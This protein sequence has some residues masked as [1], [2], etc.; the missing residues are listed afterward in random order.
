MQRIIDIWL[1]VYFTEPILLIL[2][3]LTL[4]ISIVRRQTLHAF[5]WLPL[6]VGL[7]LLV[8]LGDYA[9]NIL[10]YPNEQERFQK[11]QRELNFYT[12][13]LELL[14]FVSLIDSS[15]RIPALKKTLR[16][17][18]IICLLSFLGIY[19]VTHVN[20]GYISYYY[21]N[22]IYIIELATLLCSSVFFFIQLFREP[23][24]SNLRALPEFWIAIGLSFYCLCTLPLTIANSYFFSSSRGPVYVNLFSIIY[25]FYIILFS[26][27]IRSML[28]RRS[29]TIS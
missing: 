17:L 26:L 5:R 9:Y 21:L 27:I 28:C 2:L 24:V 16:W 25:V 12:T 1:E 22:T 10:I 3:M 18:T 7:F 6:Y 13:V 23:P 20:R 29:E 11:Y 4:V 15:L 19:V 8:F 14:V